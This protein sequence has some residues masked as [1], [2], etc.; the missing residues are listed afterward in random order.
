MIKNPEKKNPH[1]VALGRLGGR[2]KSQK[3]AAAVRVNGAL[4]GAPRTYPKGTTALQRYHLRNI[5]DQGHVITSEQQTALDAVARL[6][7]KEK[8]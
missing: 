6:R 2:V 3:K 4:G 8:S 1:A 5:A 7:K